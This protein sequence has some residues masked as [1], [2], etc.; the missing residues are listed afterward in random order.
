MSQTVGKTGQTF[1]SYESQVL[2]SIL[3]CWTGKKVIF[4]QIDPLAWMNEYWLHG[5][6]EE[7]KKKKK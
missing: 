5:V 3:Y 4:Y 2:N 6:L 1:K 7:K